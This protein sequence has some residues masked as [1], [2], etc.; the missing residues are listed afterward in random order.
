MTISR[1]ECQ[2]T[3]DGFIKDNK[4]AY[5]ADFFRTSSDSINAMQSMFIGGIPWRGLL[6]TYSSKLIKIM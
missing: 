2:Q 4:K 1:L 5:L 3:R 6:S